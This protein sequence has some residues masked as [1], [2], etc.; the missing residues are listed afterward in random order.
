MLITKLEK[1]K[2]MKAE[3]KAEILKTLDIL[4]N[5]ITK[6]RDE[7]KAVSSS[8]NVLKTNRSKAQVLWALTFVTTF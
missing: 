7:L 2:S 8:G 3:D 6:L 4:T 5:S 1:N